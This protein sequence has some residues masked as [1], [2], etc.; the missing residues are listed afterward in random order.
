[1][2]TKSGVFGGSERWRFVGFWKS[3]GR[4]DICVD[5]WIFEQ[6]EQRYGLYLM[7]DFGQKEQRHR[8]ICRWI[9]NRRS[10]DIT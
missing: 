1:M 10:R 5:V 9:L 4:T 8:L 6:E 7:P 2:V 3:G